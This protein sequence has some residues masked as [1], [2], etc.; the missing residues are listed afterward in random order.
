LHAKDRD[1][2]HNTVFARDQI[3]ISNWA[4]MKL[5]EREYLVNEL[6]ERIEREIREEEHRPVKA[7]LLG[8]TSIG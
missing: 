2:L 8:G 3:L 7:A 1:A 5:S 4:A 6:L